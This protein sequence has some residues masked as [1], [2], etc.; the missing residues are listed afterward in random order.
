MSQ[1]NLE[2]TTRSLRK[3]KVVQ[4][5]ST[6]DV[7][8]SKKKAVITKAKSPA[9]RAAAARE[10]APRQER[11]AKKI[12]QIPTLPHWEKDTRVFVF[13]SGEQAELGLGPDM[14]V[15]KKPMPLTVLDDEKIV[16]IATGGQHCVAVTQEGKVQCFFTGLLLD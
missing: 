5:T 14:L 9:E 7:G 8:T 13:G 16:Y 3:R 10:K 15:R 12:N 1:P 6:T 2:D 4:S 11:S